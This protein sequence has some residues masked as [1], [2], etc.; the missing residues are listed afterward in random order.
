VAKLSTL[1]AKLAAKLG[2]NL[3]EHKE[4]N[5]DDQQL[6][7]READGVLLF[8]QGKVAFNVSKRCEFCEGLFLSNISAVGFCSDPCRKKSLQAI[9]IQWDPYKSQEERWGTTGVPLVIGPQALAVL[10]KLFVEYEETNP[11]TPAEDDK[12]LQELLGS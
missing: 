9:G 3:E 2:I 8:L 6:L 7:R 11:P 10:R 5:R 1:E 12:F 4:D